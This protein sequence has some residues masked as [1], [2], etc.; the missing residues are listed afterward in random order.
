MLVQSVM[1][2][3]VISIK[4][5]TLVSDTAKLMDEKKI[6]CVVVASEQKVEGIVTDSD[7]IFRVV[8]KGLDPKAVLASEMM[9]KNPAIISPDV[10][11]FDAIRLME[12][13]RIRRL[14]VVKD[15]KLVGI[16]SIGDVSA[17]LMVRMEL[18]RSGAAK[19]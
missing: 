8:S 12:E 4:S 19:G 10:D 16:L 7:I 17:N 13:R 6:R 1:T 18:I 5:E 2:R 14:P 11:I 9:T 3:D 15:G